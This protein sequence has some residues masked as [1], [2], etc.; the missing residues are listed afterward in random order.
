MVLN[1]KSI[2]YTQSFH[3]YPDIAP[4]LKSLLVPP[5]KQGRFKYTLLAICHLSS[6]KSS[7]SGAMIDSLLIVCHLNET[8]LDPPLFPSGEASYTLALA[9]GK[10]RLPAALK[11]CDLLL[12]YW[13]GPTKG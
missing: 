7:P 9:V 12:S 13:G 10:L 5:Y 11:M 1:Y 4:L 3:S 6:V 8:Y 2:P